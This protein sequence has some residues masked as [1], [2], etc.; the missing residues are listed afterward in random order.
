MNLRAEAT[1]QP[2]RDRSDHAA[3]VCAGGH[4]GPAC[5]SEPP[6][7]RVRSNGDPVVAK[8]LDDAFERSATFRRLVE[9]IN[10]TDGI[11]YIEQ[12]KCGS[13]F[14]CLLMSVTVAG[15]NRVLHVRVD[16]APCV[17]SSACPA[18]NRNRPTGARTCA[19]TSR[20]SCVAIDNT[21]GSA[22]GD[23]LDWPRTPRCHRSPER[24]RRV[25][26]RVC[27]EFK[28][29]GRHRRGKCPAR[30]SSSA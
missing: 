24:G 17:F 20:R 10:D 13:G 25:D 29:S 1:G 19:T 11:V 6:M 4:P 3:L 26:G 12:G 14:H 27:F 22:G 2:S 5:A 30:P 21:S 15:P 8:L 23:G 18:A 9:T 16:I 7:M 28:L